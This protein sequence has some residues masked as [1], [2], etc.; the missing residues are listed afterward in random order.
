MAA[1]TSLTSQL[2]VELPIVQAPMA[3]SSGVAL[4]VAVA[5]AGGLGSLPTAVLPAELLEQQIDEF[6]KS[7]DAPVNV[8]FFCHREPHISGSELEA[9]SAVISRYDQELGVDRAALPTGP[10]RNAFDDEACRLVE[11]RHPEVVSFHFG[12]PPPE[13]VERVRATGAVVMSSAT[14]VAEAV[15]LEQHGCDVVIAQG[16][17]AGGHRGMFLT[18]DV[19]AQPGTM[20]LVPRVVDAV[21]VP[22]I[23]AGGIADGRGVAA[24]LVL[25]A[26]A[27]QLGTAYL[28]CPEAL[29]TPVHRRALA[30]GSVDDTVLTNVFTGR[31]ARGR[32]NRLI[33]EM[34]PISEQ[35]PP[36]P[37]A[38]NAVAPLRAAAEATGSG[39][40]SPLWSGQAGA[41]TSD[42]PA[43]DLTRRLF[44][45]ARGSLAGTTVRITPP[46]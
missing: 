13:L 41:L 43:F 5:R 21:A 2:G 22:V 31:P 44:D 39:D 4:A 34:G 38:G 14:T 29:T 12:L 6:R 42:V 23:A 25:G 11:R 15:W 27:A 1:R 24:A 16:A 19:L 3:G 30:G 37:M 17:E 45:D 32:R 18:D 20:A 26:S 10:A 8:N 9:W 35:A 7:V 33:D 36:F 40:F 46:A 28:L